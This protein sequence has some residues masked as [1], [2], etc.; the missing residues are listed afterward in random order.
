MSKAISR[1]V[2]LTKAGGLTLSLGVANLWRPRTAVARGPYDG[3]VWLAGDHHIHT[4]FSPDGMYEI[5][6]QVDAAQRHGLSW[7]VITDHGGPKHDK[8]AVQQA[9]P[10]LVAARAKHPGMSIFQ[11]LEWNVPAAEH[12]S[13]ILPPTPDE[14]KVIA[15]FE[16]LYDELNE[17]REGTP[18]NTEAEAVAAVKYLESLKP[19]PLFFANHPARRGRNSP[20]EMRNWGDAG[21]TVMRGFEAA[22]G[23]QAAT[24]TG[25]IRGHYE[26]GPKEDSWPGYP[27]ESYR[28]W[29]GYDWYVTKIGGVW[30]SLLGEGRPWYI[31]A[32]SDSHRHYTEH[33]RVNDKTYKTLG[34]VTTLDEQRKK[35][36]TVDLIDFWPGEYTKPWVYASAPEP[37]AIMNALRAGSMFPVHGDLIDR[38]E[39]TATST[40]AA[41]PMGGTLLLER[42]GQDVSIQVRIRQPSRPN[43]AGRSM[44]VHHLDLI[45]G[46]FTG[47]AKDRAS[48]ENPST[49]VVQRFEAKDV[50]QE[51]G[52]LSFSQT[53]K[54][55]H[56]SFYVRVRGTN[57]DLTEP[58]LDDLKTNPWDDLWFYSNPVMIR[59]R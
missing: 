2:F 35:D 27:I 56:K 26:K 45:A 3:G 41:A 58:E 19:S 13:V 32:D 12:A 40:D 34:Y 42:S 22:A 31:T 17:S 59:V 46:D 37:I 18:A 29:C 11:G 57:R 36:E 24:L 5:M 53:F 33:R 16:A 8:I 23:H 50:K 47:P 55:V 43:F 30:D 52:W 54:N 25:H 1:R 21:P 28:T 14:A 9:Y 49:R 44:S 20:M 10:D 6:Q 51:G 48:I 4:K 7:C 38:L 15:E 39:L